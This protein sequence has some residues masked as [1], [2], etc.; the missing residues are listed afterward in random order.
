METI[1]DALTGESFVKTRINQ[2][3]ATSANRIK[4]YNN[5]ANKLRHSTANIN[6]PLLTNLKVLNKLMMEKKEATFHKQFLIGMGFS[7][8]VHTHVKMHEGKNHYA[9]YNF[10][11]ITAPNEQIIIIR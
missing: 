2:K 4:F 8:G 1:K 5:Q 9:I 6:K 7:F 10:I 3:F 11:V